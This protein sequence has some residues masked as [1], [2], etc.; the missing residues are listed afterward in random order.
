ML[1]YF[2]RCTQDFVLLNSD[3]TIHT[4]YTFPISGIFLIK[5]YD[6]Y[7]TLLR[8]KLFAFRKEKMFCQLKQ[9]LSKKSSYNR[10][11]TIINVKVLNEDWIIGVFFLVVVTFQLAL[12]VCSC[13]L[14]HSSLA[15]FFYPTKFFDNH[16]P[17]LKLKFFILKLW[18]FYVMNISTNPHFSVSTLL[19]VYFFIYLHLRL[20]FCIV[21]KLWIIRGHVRLQKCF[22]QNWLILILKSHCKLITGTIFFFLFNFCKTVNDYLLVFLV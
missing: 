13:R 4:F 16:N 12:V 7:E 21:F 8:M 10:S 19:W 22:T 11:L 5:L 20:H 1:I 2:I 15:F 3:M 9:G 6:N 18:N 14:L 17:I